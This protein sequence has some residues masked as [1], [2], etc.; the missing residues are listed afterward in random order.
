LVSFIVKKRIGVPPAAAAFFI[1]HP[2][3]FW[4]KALVLPLL[5]SYSFFLLL[6]PLLPLRAYQE[7]PKEGKKPIG[8]SNMEKRNHSHVPPTI[9]TTTTTTTTTTTNK[10]HYHH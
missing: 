4:S 5:P 10:S 7:K 2:S 6:L 1:V 8:N 3:P 9:H